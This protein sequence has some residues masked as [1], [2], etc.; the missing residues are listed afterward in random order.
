MLCVFHD[1]CTFA[2]CYCW[3]L[4]CCCRCLSI[5]TYKAKI[6]AQREEGEGQRKT[7]KNRQRNENRRAAAN[8][9][10][11]IEP[12]RTEANRTEPSE[13]PFA[14]FIGIAFLLTEH[15]MGFVG[16]GAT[17]RTYV[18]LAI[19]VAQQFNG[20]L[21]TPT[22]PHSHTYTHAPR[23]DRNTHSLCGNIQ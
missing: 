19:V 16:Q 2:P 18:V 4:C 14:C 13:I 10:T 12:N 1:V 7:K 17:G 23:L 21:S 8:T 11:K 22:Q 5:V 6:S 3:L 15:Q 20:V 9:G